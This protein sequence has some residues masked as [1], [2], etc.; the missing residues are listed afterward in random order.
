[1]PRIY[2]MKRA[3]CVKK[4]ETDSLCLG[5]RKQK[6]VT[7]LRPKEPKQAEDWRLLA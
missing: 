3:Q 6:R 7:E 5:C 2:V 1:M 4:M